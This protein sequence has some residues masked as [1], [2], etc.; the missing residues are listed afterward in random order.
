VPLA[1]VLVVGTEQESYA[2]T[3]IQT[4][5]SV[6]FVGVMALAASESSK[7]A[8]IDRGNGLI[9]DNVLNITWIQDVALSSTL[10]GPGIFNWSGANAWAD[11]LVYGGYA[12]LETSPVARAKGR[13]CRARCLVPTSECRTRALSML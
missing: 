9:Y 10:G 4:A 7:A 11:Q 1:V 2:M 13:T 6:L 12:I 5:A 8:L 3:K